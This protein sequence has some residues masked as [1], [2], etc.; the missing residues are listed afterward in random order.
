MKKFVTYLSIVLLSCFSVWFIAVPSKQDRAVK[1]FEV[2]QVGDSQKIIQGW[3]GAPSFTERLEKKD[4]GFH[5]E[6]IIGESYSFF[7]V[8]YIFYYDAS[9]RLRDKAKLT[10]E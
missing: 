8:R 5:H 2:A 9:L 6:A 4:S 10:S 7:L 3:L 1:A